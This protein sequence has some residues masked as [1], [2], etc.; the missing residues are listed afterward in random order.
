MRAILTV[1]SVPCR[2]YGK[3]IIAMDEVRIDPPYTPN[4]C[5]ADNSK[6]NALSYVQRLVGGSREKM[7]K[8]EVKGG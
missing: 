8:K 3:T 6:S 4:S 2:W 7:S 5:L 1:S